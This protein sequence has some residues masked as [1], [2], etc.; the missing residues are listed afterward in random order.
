MEV[1]AKIMSTFVPPRWPYSATLLV[2]T[3]LENVLIPRLKS[4]VAK[5]AVRGGFVSADARGLAGENIGA[6]A[7]AEKNVMFRVC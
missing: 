5:A 2:R 6:L 3:Y 4:A 7:D 1:L